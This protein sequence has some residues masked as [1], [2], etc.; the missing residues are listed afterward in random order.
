[1]TK[2]LDQ[3]RKVIRFVLSGYI[4]LHALFLVDGHS[5]FIGLLTRWLHLS[6]AETVTLLLLVA[7]TFVSCG[8]IWQTTI[9]CLYIFFFPFILMG[10]VLY[11]SGK[12]AFAIAR[13]LGFRPR[14]NTIDAP[15][16]TKRENSTILSAPLS[17]IHETALKENS[18]VFLDVMTRPLRSWTV[19]W[20]L[21]CLSAVHKPVMWVSLLVLLSHLGRSLFRALRL[22]LFS[23]SWLAQLEGGIRSA[24]NQ[25]IDK[26]FQINFELTP[27]SE[28]KTLFIQI[29]AYE[30]AVRFVKESPI[31][32]RATWGIGLSF[33]GLLYT[34]FAF[35]FSFAYFG[36]AHLS[37]VQLSWPQAF[38]S[39]L[40][41]PIYATNLPE[42]FW[43]RVLAGIQFTS[44]VAIGIGTV[45]N[46]LRKRVGLLTESAQ[47]ML[48]RLSEENTQQKYIVLQ[49]KVEGVLDGPT[50]ESK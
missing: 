30:I 49:Q 10:K 40:F 35:L 21:L 37:N 11:Y 18:R 4:W 38:V 13:S 36:L 50:G 32:A 8:G 22:A 34:Y 1:M 16:E 29:R 25:R 9:N 23:R 42:T 12:L 39:A 45:L 3:T 19:L 44:V 24:V 15:T 43:I 31:F 48:S 33:I 26:L 27:L 6:I 2:P 28:L 17:E 14:K 20:C 46:Y 7:F 47:A 41:I 5:K